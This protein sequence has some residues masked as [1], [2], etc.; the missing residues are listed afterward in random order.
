MT[1]LHT[2]LSNLLA[3]LRQ[4]VK[5][6]VVLL[7]SPWPRCTLFL[8]ISDG[9][10]R[11]KVLNVSANDFE[12]A[13]VKMA[14]QGQRLVRKERLCP[15]WIRVDWVRSARR[16][17]WAER[18]KRFNNIKR[19]YFRYGLALDDDFKF[20]LHEQELNAN[21]VFYGGNKIS[22][23][24]LNE[25]NF[26]IYANKRFKGQGFTADYADDRPAHRLET[27]GIFCAINEAPMLLYPTGRNSGRRIVESLD[28]DAVYGLIDRSSRYLSRQVKRSGEFYYGWHPC[29]DRLIRTYNTLRH[30]STVYS[31]LEAWG[32]TRDE[33]LKKSIDRALRYLTGS[34]IKIVDRNGEK[35]AFLTERNNEIKLG[36]NAVSLLALT[37]YV[38]VT[39]ED[40]YGPLIEML[41]LGIR[42]MQNPETGGFVHVL[43]YPSLEIKEEFRVIYYDGEAAFGLMR[44]YG[45]TKD[46]RWLEMV[47]K[48]FEHFIAQDYWKH[49][50]HWLSYCINELTLC[51]PEEKYYQFGINNV[52]GHLDFVLE[53]ITTFPTLLELMMAAQ[54]MIARLEESAEHR[55]LLKAI[56]IEK[57]YKALHFRAHYLLNGHMWPE[58]AMYF[59]NPE[60]ILGAFFI[61]HH[62]FR[63]RIDDV[64]HYLSGYVAYMNY[65]LASNENQST[66]LFV[67]RRG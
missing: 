46:P 1:G 40:K 7:E 52:A 49:H 57:F 11:A 23:C 41:A 54:R 45:L 58:Y 14:S 30:A 60:R 19:N 8:S 38:E 65:L 6:N 42:Y 61:R 56:D 29:F 28:A 66:K 33:A 35:M 50:D 24:V 59:K 47:E 34:L 51:R 26:T 13:W 4:E 31:M 16:S 64:E 10:S 43:E 39:G 21:A 12:D 9:Y 55:H 22:H 18:K 62:A 17:T 32:A 53:R 37:K 3:I 67:G 5:D 44:A 25:K 2:S 63:I 36:G 27:Q 15:R 48:A 20:S